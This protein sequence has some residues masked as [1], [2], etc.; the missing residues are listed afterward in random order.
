MRDIIL[1][2][3]AL[4]SKAQ[5]EKISALLSEQYRTHLLNLPG[6]GGEPFSSEAFSMRSFAAHVVAYIH[7]HQLHQPAI[8]GFSMGGYV[9]MQ[10][11]ADHP[12]LVGSI[13]TLG[14]K[15]YWDATIATREVKHLQTEVIEEKIPAF[16]KEL[17]ARHSPLDWKDQM[18][19]TAGLLISLGEKNSLELASYSKIEIPC[20]LL[21]GDRDKMIT[22][23]ETTDVYHALPNAAMAVLPYTA[24]P[25]EKIDIELLKFFIDRFI[26]S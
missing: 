8:F 5:L 24:H 26:A 7:T 11:A 25:I 18:R 1:L 20:L 22:L 12:G 19:R 9:A 6:H 21:L 17:A 3:G 14:T 10:I 13:I 23:S 16:A 4:G 15:F 2:H